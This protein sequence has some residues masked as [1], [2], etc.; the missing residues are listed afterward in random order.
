MP[1]KPALLLKR[2][3]NS[4][5]KAFSNLIP[6]GG[7]SYNN[8]IKIFHS[9]DEAFAAIFDAISK[10]KKSIYI[11]TYILSPDNLGKNLQTELLKAKER[12]VLVTILYDHVGSQGLTNAYLAIFKKAGIKVVEFNPIWPWR[13]RGPLLFRNHRKIMVI[14]NVAFCGS[15]NI[16]SDYAGPIYG[17]SRFR[18]TTALVT[19]P[20]VEDLLEITEESIL[21][22][23]FDKSAENLT[24]VVKQKFVDRSKAIKR[25]FKR[26]F[27]KEPL[28]IKDKNTG[29]LIQVLRSNTRRN[30]YHIQKSIEESVN[31]AVDYCYFTTPYFLPHDGLRKALINASRR[32]VDVR[33]LTAGLSD[34]PLM[35]YASRHIYKGF[36][37]RGI[38]IYEMEDQTL[39]AKLASIDGIYSLLGSYNLDHWS[40]RRNLEVNLAIIDQ[41]TALKLK[42]Q[43]KKDLFKAKE[44]DK[45]QFFARSKFRR[46]LCWLAYLLMRL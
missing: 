9:G 12:G 28:P 11:E 25:F 45:D 16:S 2:F 13:K 18:D 23:Q 20:V 40:A 36:L 43:F 8:Q 33:I 7:F 14:D 42:E 21:E 15:M 39:H 34:V 17:N 31:R 3:K 38:R 1:K 22:S 41:E 4:W 6:L 19:G 44:I 10:A 26:L 5:Q 24:Q 30:L 35:R 29:V 46:F 32:K 37:E 27:V